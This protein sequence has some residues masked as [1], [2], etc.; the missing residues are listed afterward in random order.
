[1]SA[2]QGLLSYHLYK[3]SQGRIAR[4]A[5]FAALAI[6]VALGCWKLSDR[7]GGQG[8]IWR[9][10]NAFWRWGLPGVLLL[11]GCWLVF[12]LVNKQTFADFLIAVEAEMNKVSW[13]S[14]KELIRA[15]V[16]VI[17][18][19][20]LLAIVLFGYDLFWQFLLYDLLRIA[21]KG[22]PVGG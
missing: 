9:L 6:V 7:L 18:T 5:T 4:Q 20:F 12:K 21:P 16:V 1:M 10:P 13:P 19:I 11:A 3:R 14:R 2:M 15:S 8:D 17:I 22:A